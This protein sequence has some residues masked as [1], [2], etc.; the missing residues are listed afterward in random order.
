VFHFKRNPAGSYI[1]LVPTTLG[2]LAVV[3]LEYVASD[4]VGYFEALLIHF[5]GFPFA[6]VYFVMVLRNTK[7]RAIFVPSAVLAAI[8]AL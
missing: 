7:V 1:N 6:Y 8:E 5:A 3:F 2:T 4:K